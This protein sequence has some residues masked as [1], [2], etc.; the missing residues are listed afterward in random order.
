MSELRPTPEE[1]AA[2]G[3]DAGEV[4]I[5]KLM[6]ALDGSDPLM[7]YRQLMSALT[8]FG[9][10]GYVR[11]PNESAAAFDLRFRTS[12]MREMAQYQ[13]TMRPM[14]EARGLVEP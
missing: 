7:A 12:V 10:T 4:D 1:L 8:L 6:H 2:A 14:L 13:S 9:F 3:P 11:H 5:T